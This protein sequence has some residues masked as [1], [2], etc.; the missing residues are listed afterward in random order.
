M[1]HPAWQRVG[2]DVTVHDG[3]LRVVRR[4]YS[5]P[6]GTESDWE[7]LGEFVSVSVLALT[8]AGQVVLVR[9]FRP[10]PDAVVH[11]L[12]GGLVDEGESV[13]EAA[14]RE[15]AQETGYVARQLDAVASF[16][17]MAHGGWVKHVVVARGCTVGADQALDALEDCVPVLVTPEEVRRAARAGELVGT[18]VVYLALDHAGLL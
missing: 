3:W 13:L 17:P 9:Q 15:L 16:H 4:R 14:A 10:G 11:N 6:D 8:D 5:M 1:T 2:D 18:D 12:P 7:L